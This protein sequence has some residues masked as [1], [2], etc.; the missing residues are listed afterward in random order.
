MKKSLLA[1]A[2]LGSFVGAASA[3]SS[4]TVFG[5]VDLSINS[6]KNGSTTI[7][8]MDNNQLNSNRLG[9]RGVEDLGGG[10]TASFWLEG[11]MANDTGNP[12]GLTFTR[13]STASLSGGFGE[14]R[15]GRDYVNSFSTPA[16]FDA[17]GANGFANGSN[18]Y[19]STA[20]A[21]GSGA[22]TQ[23]R[24]NNMVGYFLPSNLGGVYGSVQVSAGEGVVGNKYIGFRVGYAAGPVDASLGFSNTTVASSDKY[25]TF[26]IGGS[27]N[28]GVAKLYGFYDQRKFGALKYTTYELSAGV[29]LGQG[30]FRA[31]YSK[32]NAEGGSTSA[33]DASLFGV[34][35]IYNLSKRTAL[36]TQYGRLS[37]K[38]ASALTVGLGTGVAGTASSGYGVGVRHSF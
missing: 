20:A 16:G 36:Y 13:R 5:I 33:N 30:E 21:L 8:S 6:V 11:G 37:N 38:G 27:Y 1:L 9:F 29:P 32:G 14:I 24:A 4:L 19:T 26:N 3:Q 18:L 22:A 10:L 31:A 15:L 25:K 35:Y 28:L 12:G 23:V 17:Y 7:K 34:E 2:V